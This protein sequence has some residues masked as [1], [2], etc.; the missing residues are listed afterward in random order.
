M[1]FGIQT[2]KNWI[3]QEECDA[4]QYE[5]RRKMNRYLLIFVLIPF[6]TLLIPYTS[7]AIT[8]WMIWL[9]A[10]IVA[11]QLPFALNNKRLKQLK[12]E[13]C[14]IKTDSNII[15]PEIKP[16]GNIRALKKTDFLLPN[17]LCIGIVV[18][19][20]F[21]LH[22]E[23]FELYSFLIITFAVC[24]PL[25]YLC[26]LLMDRS[27][28]KIISTDIDVNINYARAT[29]KL[30]KDF[31]KT[32]IWFNTLFTAVLLAIVL[33]KNASVDFTI[34]VI[35]WGSILYCVLLLFLCGFIWKKKLQLD[36]E[37]ADK[38]DVADENDEN[39]WIGGI[40]YYNPKDPHTMVDKNFGI[41]TT[42]NMATP[43]GKTT[44]L[45]GILACLSIP[46]LCVWMMMEE[47]T[48][49]SLS[50]TNNTLIAEHWKT[51]Y[52]I[53]VDSITD[54]TLLEELPRT[55][56]VS[57]TG[58]DNLEKVTFRTSG[59][60]KIQCF[61]NPQNDLFLRFTADGTIYYMS[62]FDDEETM[63]IYDALLTSAP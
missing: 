39:A 51:D 23:R 47:F 57:G 50:I 19:S 5:Y 56:K 38:M 35:L 44:T 52:K 25:F 31:S 24:T 29:K 41:G 10:A 62:G 6:I 18:F 60:G 20:L 17:L 9:M 42:V 59:D 15:Y 14:G 33:L 34:D 2:S 3:S 63:A 7:I 26:A 58:M 36:E 28:S 43:V 32:C 4:I 13:R 12:Q 61:L 40:L 22:D 55:S 21:C 45:I 48:P 27:K 16:A 37:Y 49:I 11:F 30:W 8:V 53:P 46:I 54:V 1:L